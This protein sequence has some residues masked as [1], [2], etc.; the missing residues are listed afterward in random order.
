MMEAPPAVLRSFR[1]IAKLDTPVHWD[2]GA[3]AL[4]PLAPHQW[5]GAK[6]HKT[7]QSVQS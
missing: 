6:L 2:V 4:H 5:K 7:T 3:E 1:Y